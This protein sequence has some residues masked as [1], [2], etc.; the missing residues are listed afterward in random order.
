M[1][2]TATLAAEAAPEE[3]GSGVDALLA[4][5][6]EKDEESKFRDE[7][8]DNLHKNEVE[9]TAKYAEKD[10]LQATIDDLSNTHHRPLGAFPAAPTMTAG[11]GRCPPRSRRLS[12]ANPSENSQAKRHCPFPASNECHPSPLSQATFE[13]NGLPT[14][15]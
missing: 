11:L 1:P 2:A 6:A 12:T 15:P 7:C 4:E 10:D 13:A 3:G 9:T 5:D 14:T 8:T